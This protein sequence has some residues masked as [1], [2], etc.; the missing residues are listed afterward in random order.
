MP[1]QQHEHVPNDPQ[2]Q[3]TT[4]Q[5]CGIVLHRQWMPA[6]I[7]VVKIKEVQNDRADHGGS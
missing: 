1:T 7:R 5:E 3:Q 2:N 4:C 6:R